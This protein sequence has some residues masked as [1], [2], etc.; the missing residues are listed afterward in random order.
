MMEATN[1]TPEETKNHYISLMGDELG[2]LFYALWQ[3]V[4]WLHNEWH[5]YVELF[6]TKE[7][8]ITLMNEAAPEFFRII[9]D[10]LFD[11][12][13][14]RIAR[15]TD[16]PK[17]VGKSNLTIRQLPLRIKDDALRQKVSDLVDIAVAAANFCR[18]R[19]HRHLAHRA[20]D[21]SLGVTTDPL[22]SLTRKNISDAIVSLANVLNPV[23]FHY[24]H[25]TTEFGLI[26]NLG[27]ALALIR[28]LDDGVQKKAE[29]MAA[30][31]RGEIPG[32]GA[33]RQNL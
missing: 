17:S 27:G 14:L 31:N 8:R 6:G 3:E 5:E 11:M 1:R 24:V 30:L 2:N 26:S 16:P 23:S 18:E 25:S 9:Q 10:G 21:L 7:S 28:I 29:R 33:R 19:R 4:A 12:I 13:V 32:D 15:L 22:P 20:L